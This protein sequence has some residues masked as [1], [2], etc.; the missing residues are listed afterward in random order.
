MAAPRGRGHTAP[1]ANI[2]VSQGWPS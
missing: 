2:T 1:A